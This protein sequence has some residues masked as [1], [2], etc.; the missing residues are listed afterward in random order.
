MCSLGKFCKCV[1]RLAFFALTTIQCIFLAIY[2]AEWY[3]IKKMALGT[4]FAPAVIVWLL[5]LAFNKANLRWFFLVWYLY[6]SALICNV[7]VIFLVVGDSID[8]NKFLNQNKLKMVLCITPLLIL[9]LLYSADDSD[10]NEEHRDLVSKLSFQMAIDLFD[11]VELMDIVLEDNEHNFGLP[12][13]LRIWMVILACLSLLVSTGQLAEYKPSPKKVILRSEIAFLR[14]FIQIIFVNSLFLG[15]RG[16]VSFEYGK[17]ESIFI[18]KNGIGII[19]SFLKI[20]RICCASPSYE[21]LSVN[22]ESD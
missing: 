5:L 7:V 20:C 3:G 17:D 10:R 15:I 6:I 16:W 11:V 2:P 22:D 18:A 12:K 13:V 9:L 4:S 1:A 21:R 19:F 14:N 8:N